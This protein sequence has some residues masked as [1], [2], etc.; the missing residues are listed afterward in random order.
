MSQIDFV[1]ESVRRT[2][3]LRKT[4]VVGVSHKSLTAAIENAWQS[5]RE[6]GIE[7]ESDSDPVVLE[8][9]Y[10]WVE[11]VNPITVFGVVLAPPAGKGGS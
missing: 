10:Q 2:Q 7:R 4:I 8:V 11:A 1:A 5:V 6:V 9:V 3:A